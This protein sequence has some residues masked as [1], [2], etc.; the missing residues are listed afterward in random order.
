MLTAS[1]ASQLADHGPLW[2]AGANMT[3]HYTTLAHPA[4]WTHRPPV[5]DPA[6][7]ASFTRAR[8][9][10]RAVFPG[11]PL[12]DGWAIMFH[13]A[14]LTAVVAV[15]KLYTQTGAVPSTGAVAQELNQVTVHGAS[16]YLCFDARHDP[17]N[18]A[19]PV[20][21]LDRDGH[22]GDVTLLSA[23]GGAP[24]GDHCD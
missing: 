24:V 6:T 21:E 16:G 14:V 22:L 15:N 12:D 18:K 9:G 5:V 17:I 7:V 3:V 10:Y 20:V 1:D 4:L 19:I 13:D 11:E 23:S 8:Y 2:P